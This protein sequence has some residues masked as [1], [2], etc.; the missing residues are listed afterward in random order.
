MQN[1]IVLLQRDLFQKN[2]L[3]K[4]NRKLRMKIAKPQNLKWR[5]QTKIIQGSRAVP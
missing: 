4:L 3:T 5:K 2:F 1:I